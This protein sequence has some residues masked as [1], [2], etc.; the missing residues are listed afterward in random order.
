MLLIKNN[1]VLLL[2][3]QNTGYADGKYSLVSG[4]VDKGETMQE[5]I[6]REAKE[7][8]GIKLLK[9]NLKHVLTLHRK[10]LDYERV[11]LFFTAKKWQGKISNTEPEKCSE[12]NWYPVNK[13]PKNTI[14]YVKLAIKSFLIKETYLEY[15]WK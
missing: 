5:A 7:E 4:H 1:K 10:A 15:G 12:L 9:R 14:T 6:I 13:P 3:R 2:K 11:D 8:A